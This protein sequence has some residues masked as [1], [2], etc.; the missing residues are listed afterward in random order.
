VLNYVLLKLFLSNF[1]WNARVLF[2]QWNYRCCFLDFIF[3]ISMLVCFFKE[4]QN[5]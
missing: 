3:W 5:R 2:T 4:N 1:G